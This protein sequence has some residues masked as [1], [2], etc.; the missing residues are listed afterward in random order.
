MGLIIK[1]GFISQLT[2]THLLFLRK[3]KN[4][5]EPNDPGIKLR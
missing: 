3:L 5:A 4:V 1:S 2:K